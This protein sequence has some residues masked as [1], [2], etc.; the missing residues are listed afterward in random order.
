[1]TILA[2]RPLTLAL[3]MSA[4]LLFAFA[5]SAQAADYFVTDTTDT[6]GTCA[7]GPGSGCTLRQAFETV[8]AGSGGDTIHVAAGHYV[9]MNGELSL[10]KTATVVGE[11]AKTTIIDGNHAT[12]VFAFDA[13]VTLR[14]MLVT[15]GVG[16]QPLAHAQTSGVGGA[17]NNGTQT[18]SNLTLDHVAV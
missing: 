1:M 5:A 11:S 14:N 7:A 18:Q 6:G 4:F 17:I 15:G 3:W 8:E 2:R 10:T 9:L 16:R 12:R 13:D